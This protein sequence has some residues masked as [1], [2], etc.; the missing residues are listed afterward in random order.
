MAVAGLRQAVGLGE[1]RVTPEMPQPKPR[2]D[3]I[4]RDRPNQQDQQQRLG[5]GDMQHDDA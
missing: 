2:H 3:Q 1:K 5:I 4:G